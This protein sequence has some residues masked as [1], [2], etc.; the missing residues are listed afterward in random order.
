MLHGRFWRLI[1]GVAAIAA[2][3]ASST[4]PVPSLDDGAPFERTHF[5]T[6]LTGNPNHFGNSPQSGQQPITILANNTN[7]NSSVALVTTRTLGAF[8]QQSRS[9]FPQASQAFWVNYGSG[10]ISL[11]FA[12]VNTHDIPD[13]TDCNGTSTKPLYYTLSIKFDSEHEICTKP[14]LPKIR[15]I[16]SWDQEPS[17]TDPYWSPVWGNSMEEYVQ[18]LASHLGGCHDTSI[19]DGRAFSTK[20]T[21]LSASPIEDA[22]P[23]DPQPQKTDWEELTC[24]GPDRGLSSLVATVR[25]KQEIGYSASPCSDQAFEF[26]SFWADWYDNCQW[27]FLGTAKFNVHDFSSDF[28]STGLVYTVILP[29][30]LLNLSAPCNET[31]IVNVRASL[32]FNSIPPVPP[33]VASRGNIIQTHVHLQPYKG[34]KNPKTPIIGRI[35]G[36]NVDQIET[37]DAG[38]GMT[39]PNAQFFEDGSFADPSL[40]HSRNCPF[41]GKNHYLWARGYPGMPVANPT[42]VLNPADPAHPHHTYDPDSEGCFPYLDSTKNP[43][44]TLG[45]WYPPDGVWQIRLEMVTPDLP[46][47]LEAYS[48]WYKV[49]VNNQRPK[50]GLELTGTGGQVCGDLTIGATVSGTFYAIS[51]YFDRYSLGLEPPGLNP[52]PF[53][54]LGDPLTPVSPWSTW[55][56]ATSGAVPCGYVVAL[57]VWDR[58][59]V[60]SVG[61]YGKRFYLNKRKGFCLRKP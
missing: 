45:F 39:I 12:T 51:P 42:D 49:L 21:V 19:A 6:L 27:T 41:G 5:R 14:V 32:A 8:Q 48:P 54:G 33:A 34:V 28:P 55:G 61:D 7:T 13:S 53:T 18:S 10:W 50:V 38:S 17:A 47:S 16:L 3:A 24:L 56:L 36:I 20:Q 46:H 2:A 44:S 40:P 23:S 52:N 22:L 43:L 35:G 59:V 4:S 31:R 30:N 29:V 1:F 25:I 57:S 60:D 15:A 37:S 26:V 11:G 9:N 58:T